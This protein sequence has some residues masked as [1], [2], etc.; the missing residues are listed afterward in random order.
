MRDQRHV[1]LIVHRE[2]CE[3]AGG[4]IGC[5]DG[6][7]GVIGDVWGLG[8]WDPEES[9]MVGFR[10]GFGL[11]RSGVGALLADSGS[12]GKAFYILFDCGYLRLLRGLGSA[13]RSHGW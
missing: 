8:V 12:I 11:S 2:A 3:E 1:L 7:L 13:L 10:G 9:D 6:E 5:V 4:W